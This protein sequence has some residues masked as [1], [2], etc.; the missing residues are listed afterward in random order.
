MF[1]GNA[2]FEP[3]QKILKNQV[4]SPVFG[5]A[6]IWNNIELQEADITFSI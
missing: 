2:R 3:N 4:E 1:L 5:T 6:F